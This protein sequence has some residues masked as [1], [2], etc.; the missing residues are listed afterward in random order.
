MSATEFNLDA[1]L[2]DTDTNFDG[3][4]GSLDTGTEDPSGSVGGF[5]ESGYEG[6]IDYRIR[7]LS[8]SSLLTL[9]QC[10]RKFEL[11]RKRTTFRTEESLKS[12]I[13]FAFGHV[14]GEAIQLA[15]EGLSEDAIIFKMFMGWH[16][17]LFAVD[18]KAAKS[19]W[20]AVTALQRFN[21]LRSQGFL[22]EYELVYY[23][24]KPA[25]ELSFSINF[26]DGFRLRGFVDA[27][28][29]H[30]VTGEILVL[31]CKTTGNSTINPA[32]Y[33]NSSQAIG[34]SVVLDHLYPEL[35][36]Y[37][38][39]YLIYQTKSREYNPIPFAK[40]FLQR[41]L[42]IRELLLDIETIKMYE[43]AEIYPM[44]GESCT[45]FGRDCEY[46][47]TCTLSTD[48][49]TKPCTPE[50]EDTTDY[51]VKI[52]LDDLLDSQLRKVQV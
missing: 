2:S 12:T 15:L 10:P 27:V 16:A 14:V 25:C 1:F 22:D 48:H 9:H 28:L 51:Q 21:E 41:A 3:L 39:L 37:K 11:Y 46:F 36:S 47:Q 24:N 33:K 8:Y 30:K 13:T 49:L 35:S 18:E 40:S 17:D 42:W 26:P 5:R 4:I 38:V 19:F 44:H 7:Q 45:S 34:Y 32:T 23:D 6:N 29:R 31:E 50:E 52:T 43:E 20:W